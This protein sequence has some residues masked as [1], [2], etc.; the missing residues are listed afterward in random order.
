MNEDVEG[1]RKKFEQKDIPVHMF[2]L[3]STDTGSP[4]G[5]YQ[6]AENRALVS[7]SRMRGKMAW[8][9][10]PTSSLFSGLLSTSSTNRD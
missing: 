5:R 2:A 9:Q 7:T 10:E 3:V 1:F 4:G 8:T 6:V